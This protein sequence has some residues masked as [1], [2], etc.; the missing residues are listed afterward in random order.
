[1]AGLRYWRAGD[2]VVAVEAWKRSGEPMAAFARRHGIH[3]RRLGRWAK[4]LA[5]EAE[6]VDFHPVRLIRGEEERGWGEP[7]EIGL[8]QGWRVRVPTG[9]LATELERVLEVLAAGGWC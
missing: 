1:M 3:R 7:I 6:A 2:A 9:F 5:G 4:R 8:G